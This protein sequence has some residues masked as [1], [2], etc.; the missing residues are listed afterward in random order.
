[1]L[2]QILT[3]GELF[4]APTW[5]QAQA[6][7]RDLEAEHARSIADPE[8]F[9]GEWAAR[10]AWFKPWDKVCLLYTSRCV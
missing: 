1:M 9:W 4:N 8:A 5:L 2:E 3:H 7:L 10:Y 6:N